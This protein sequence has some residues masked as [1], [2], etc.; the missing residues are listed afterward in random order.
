[1][2]GIKMKTGVFGEFIRQC[3][4]K[5]TPSVDL[6]EVS[7]DNPVDCCK[8][9]LN[10]S[11]YDEIQK[12]FCENDNDIVACNMWMLQSGPQLFDDLNK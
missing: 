4:L 5:S 7:K 12:E 10:M 9:I 6:N 11:D 3:Y 1:M 2:G 8:H